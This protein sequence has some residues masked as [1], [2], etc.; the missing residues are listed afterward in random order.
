MSVYRI[1]GF[2][3]LILGVLMFVFGA[4]MFTYLGDINP[5]ISEI[6]MYSFLLWMPT[7]IFGIILIC[8]PFGKE[9]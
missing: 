9:K 3:I 5:I 8:M 1:V 4:S 6:G 2:V 7:I